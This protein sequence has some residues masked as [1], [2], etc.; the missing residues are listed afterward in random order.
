VNKL[1]RANRLV[2]TIVALV[3]I[4]A[5]GLGLLRS[6]GI[7]FS[8]DAMDDPVLLRQVRDFVADNDAWFWW[9]A[10]FVALLLAYL[11]WRWLRVQLLP[12]PSLGELTVASTDAGKTTLPTRALADAVTQQLEDDPE[13]TGA[14]VRVVGSEGS[15]ELDIRASVADGADLDGVRSRVEDEAVRR[16]REALERPDL[17]ARVRYRLGDPTQRVLT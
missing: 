8:D 5:G 11:G 13:V 15:P 1:D 3:L 9:A 17:T 7:I 2:G 14:R 10:F 6:Y 16:A 12:S 4:A